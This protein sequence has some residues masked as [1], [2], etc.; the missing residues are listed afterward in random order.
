M[1]DSEPKYF[2]MITMDSSIVAHIE[3]FD[4]NNDFRKWQRIVKKSLTQQGLKTKS[5]WVVKKSHGGH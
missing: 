4:G 1:R 2:T 5:V 3:V